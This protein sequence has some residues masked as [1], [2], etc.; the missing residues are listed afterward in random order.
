MYRVNP[1]GHQKKKVENKALR[2]SLNDMIAPPPHIH[3]NHEYHLSSSAFSGAQGQPSAAGGGRLATSVAIKEANTA[4]EKTVGML[5]AA[6]MRRGVRGICGLNRSF[7][8][9]DGDG[10]K[11]L[12]PAEFTLGLQRAGLDLN[13]KEARA[14]FAYIDQ[15]GSG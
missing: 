10:D 2:S 1:I 8:V 14:L 12:D 3:G 11:K 15:D 5:K 6:L 13:V 7:R 9:M 4:T